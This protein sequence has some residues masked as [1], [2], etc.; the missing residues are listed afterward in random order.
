LGVNTAGAI[1]IPL[2]LFAGLN[3]ELA[4]SD[5]PEGVSPDNQDVAFLPGNVFSR[6]GLHKVF[7]PAIPNNATVVF[8]KTY[9]QPNG[10]PITLILDSNGILWKED[11]VNAPGVLTQLW[12]TQPGNY[13]RSITAFGRE[14]IGISDGEHGADLPLQFDGVNLDRVTQDGPGANPCV[15]QDFANAVNIVSI[16]DRSSAQTIASASSIG[17]TATI[18]TAAAHG[19]K[20]GDAVLVDGVSVPGYNGT[21]IVTAVPSS[22][23]FDYLTSGSSLGAGTGGTEYPLQVVVETDSDHGLIKGDIV[24][25][26]N[27]SNSAYNNNQSGITPSYWTVTAAPT[28]RTF[29]FSRLTGTGAAGFTV[30][31]SIPPKTMPWSIVSNPGYNYG[32]NDGTAPVVVPLALTPG[33]VLI[34]NVTGSV[35]PSDSRPYAPPDGTPPA[36]GSTGGSTGHG[37]PTRFMSLSTLGL[38]GACGTFANAG[39]VVQPVSLGSHRVVT[40]PVGGPSLQVGVNDDHF[41]D[42]LGGY[43]VT[44]TL[45]SG[46]GTGGAGGTVSIGGLSAA[47]TH[48]MVVVFETRQGFQTVPSPPLKFTT[49]GQKKIQISNVPIGPPNV[50]KRILA[51]TG[52][53]GT[54]ISTSPSTSESPET[55]SGPVQLS[56]TT[57]RRRWWSI[58]RITPYLQ[59]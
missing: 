20:V 38:G 35:K 15:I 37:F 12:Q 48:Q 18:K 33:Q 51:F 42:N 4:P 34:I 53:G 22:D 7:S 5:I 26:E 39:I 9:V 1:D 57:K 43:T 24:V 46:G 17:N 58:S 40:V 32:I 45:A 8:E 23:T 52:A 19:L 59:R 29:E 10:E 3:T 56:T 44:I 14:Y 55:S 11:V 49:A 54:T 31:V 6:P 50:I 28:A 21:Q 13:A 41:S 30:T 36:T 2:E 47:G 16:S 27:N 25:I